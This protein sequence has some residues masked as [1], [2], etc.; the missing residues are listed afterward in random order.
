MKKQ[1]NEKISLQK[2]AGIVSEVNIPDANV[3]PWIINAMEELK[4]SLDVNLNRQKDRIDFDE[5]TQFARILLSNIKK[6]R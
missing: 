4:S 2:L 1:L 3:H 6:Y 5:I